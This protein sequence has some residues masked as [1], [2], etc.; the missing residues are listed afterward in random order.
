MIDDVV[1]L[2]RVLS[3]TRTIAVVG[4]SAKPHRASFGVAQYMRDHGYTI[5]PVNPAYDTVLG[6]TCYPSLRE[7]PVP[8]DLVDCFRRPDAMLPIVDDAI[9]IGART[10]W[11][12]LGVINQAAAARAEAAG[13]HVV[14]DR[15]V[16][17]E[18]ARLFA[19]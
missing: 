12:Q 11:M 2:Q 18:H 19:K 16:K 6:E 15:C 3:E 8:V 10:L 4:M 17:I 13:L 5:I 14:M 1:G 7:V 9:H